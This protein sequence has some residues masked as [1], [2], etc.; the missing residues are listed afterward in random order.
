[1]IAQHT[2][3]RPVILSVHEWNTIAQALGYLPGVIAGPILT[4]IQAQQE[5]QDA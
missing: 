3:A 4:A 1:M 2:L 5:T